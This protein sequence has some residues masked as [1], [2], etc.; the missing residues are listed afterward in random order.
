MWDETN[1]LT[2]TKIVSVWFLN[3]TLVKNIIYWVNLVK[4]GNHRWKL[5]KW[6][7][8]WCKIPSYI[9]IFLVVRKCFFLET[10]SKIISVRFIKITL[11]KDIINWINLVKIGYLGKNG[12]NWKIFGV[13]ITSEVH[14]W[15]FNFILV[16]VSL[17]ILTRNV[18]QIV[19]NMYV[20]CFLFL[21]TLSLREKIWGSKI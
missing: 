3:I 16:G 13:K 4:K 7:H 8:F 15:T 14:F 17:Y 6:V 1:N 11:D 12:H 5:S 21:L 2:V 20:F 9:Q 19:Q 18:V 10:V